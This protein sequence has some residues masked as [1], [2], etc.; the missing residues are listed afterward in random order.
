MEKKNDHGKTW[1]ADRECDGGRRR[2][3]GW[4]K[5]KGSRFIIIA[6]CR[7]KLLLLF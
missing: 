1:N 7:L 6:F 2:G 3:P 5:E 4:W